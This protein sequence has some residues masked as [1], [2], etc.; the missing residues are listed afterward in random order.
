MIPALAVLSA[1]GG[2]GGHVNTGTWTLSAGDLA[3]TRSASGSAI[4]SSNVA[5]LQIRWRFRFRAKPNAAG[6]FASTSIADRESVYVQDLHNDVYA[7]DRATGAVRWAQRLR[8]RASGPNGLAT[9][10]GRIYGTTDTGVFALSAS[11]GRELWHVSLV[12][13]SRHHIDVAPVV[14]EGL[15]LISARGSERR[16]RGAIYAL[17]AATGRVRWKFVGIA[18][19]SYSVSVDPLGRLYANSLLVLDGATGRLLWQDQVGQHNLRTDGSEA[20]PILATAGAMNLVL[21]AGK[22]AGRVIAWNRDTRRQ[23]WAATVQLPT[24]C[25]GGLGIRTPMAY[26]NG[27]LFVPI[28]DLCG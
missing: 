6:I 27:R 7:L 21:S 10:D 3:G 16:S 22:A 20:T 11:N 25:S 28:A 9:D 23:L 24:A 26:A 2:C 1:L 5:A 13:R 8:A 19:P 18:Q 17:D 12:R 14:W 15:V 4:N